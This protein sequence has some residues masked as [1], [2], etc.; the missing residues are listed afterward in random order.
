VHY[1]WLNDQHTYTGDQLSPHWIYTLTGVLGSAL[2]AFT[3]PAAV[4]LDHMVDLEDVRLQ[5]PI[6]ADRMLH[7]I[8]EMFDVS[9]ITG[10]ALQRLWISAIHADINARGTHQLVNRE[11]NDLWWT[12]ERRKLSVAICTRSTTSV[13][14]HLAFNIDRHGAPVPTIGLAS[15]LGLGPDWSSLAQDWAHMLITEWQAIQRS[16]WKVRAVL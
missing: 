3:G 9:L 12:A 16:S 15:D 8:V 13:L 4:D 10:I 14:M 1:Q 5:A 6:K 2:V 11:G 7:F